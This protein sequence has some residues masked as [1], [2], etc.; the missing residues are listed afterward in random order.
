MFGREGWYSS[1]SSLYCEV[2]DANFLFFASPIEAGVGAQLLHRLGQI[3]RAINLVELALRV[4]TCGE[5]LTEKGLWV[6][7]VTTTN[8]LVHAVGPRR[9]KKTNK[10][11]ER[12][13]RRFKKYKAARVSSVNAMQMDI[14]T[15]G[16]NGNDDDGEE[17]TEAE[18]QKRVIEQFREVAAKRKRQKE[19]N[20]VFFFARR[21]HNTRGVCDCCD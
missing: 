8:D 4:Q 12:I 21:K 16:E 18:R 20:D 19:Y 9:W 7:A 3:T 2:T 14:A 1:S 11:L 5:S 15:E 10:R 6:R 13:L 17:E